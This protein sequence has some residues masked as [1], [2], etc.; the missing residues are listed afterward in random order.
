MLI[1]L[2]KNSHSIPVVLAA[3]AASNGSA[4]VLA[5]LYLRT[6]SKPALPYAPTPVQ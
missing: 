2:H 4:A 1:S 6:E 5:R 3:L